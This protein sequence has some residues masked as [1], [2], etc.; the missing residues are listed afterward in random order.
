MSDGS[1]LVHSREAEFHDEWAQ[2]VSVESIAVREA[3]EAPTAL[4]NQFILKQMGPLA[5]LRLLDV[6]AGLGESSVYFALQGAEVTMTDLSPGM[7]DCALRL[8]QHHGVRITGVVSAGEWLNVPEESFDLV[9]VANTIHHVTDKRKL[10]EQMR[11]A[12]KPGGR[13]FSWDPLAHNPVINIYRRMAS[14]VRTADERPLTFADFA[15]AHQYFDQV[16]HREFWIAGLFLF[17]KYY[18]VDGIHPN[19]DRY[20]KRIFRE[21]PRSLWWWYPLN[22]ADAIL[23]RLP[24]IRRLAW[25]MVMWGKKPT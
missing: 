17:L 19:A 18:L 21:T 22:A 9:Y 4:E 24:L 2:S 16:G 6:G 25:N 11:A 14:K 13:F 10:F 7:V 15:L 3:F 20:W 1:E 23:T 8:A 12:L 5:G